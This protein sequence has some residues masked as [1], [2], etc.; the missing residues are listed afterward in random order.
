MPAVTPAKNGSA[1]TARLNSSQQI[2]PSA[3]K[4]AMIP[5]MIMVVHSVASGKWSRL[6]QPP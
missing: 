3:A 2:A 1:N 5:N 6:H 4:E